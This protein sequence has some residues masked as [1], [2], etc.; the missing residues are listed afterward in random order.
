MVS[1]ILT[2]GKRI[3]SLL[4]MIIR[5]PFLIYKTKKR[6]EKDQYKVKKEYILPYK[7]PEYEKNMKYYSSNIKYLRPTRYCECNAPE[8]IAMANKLG[9]YKI[10]DREYAENVF[11]FVK[12]NI[13]SKNIPI[14]GS[15]E[16]LKKGFGSCFDAAGLFITLCRSGG[17]RARYK[18][19]LHK[20]P[21]EG[22]HTL[23]NTINENL[24]NG[25]AII[26]TFYTVAE[27]EINKRWLECEVSSNPELDVYWNVPIAHF[28]ENCSKVGGWIPDDAVHL[29][30]LPL[31]IIILTNIL[32]KLTKGL[33]EEIN[34]KTEEERFEGKKKLE[35]IG[36]EKY[37]K[38]ARRRY[39]F[40]PSLEE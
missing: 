15:L 21:P 8:I 7:I 23:S 19:Y 38:K 18:I 37:D 5:H 3:F 13:R 4:F 26:S 20:E 17:V 1:Y 11:N 16:T 40:V 6:I 36:R 29:E 33:M 22:F 30:K 25:L 12:N 24:L 27:V 9:A 14:Q 39:G 35:N 34:N 31:K 32:L 10:E 2:I 28:G